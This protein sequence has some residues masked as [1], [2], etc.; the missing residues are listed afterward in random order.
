[1]FD[2][3]QSGVSRL[4]EVDIFRRVGG[5][6][7]PLLLLHGYPQT[8]V[9]WRKIA[10]DL[11]RDFT[12]VCPDLRGYGA[13]SKPV[14]DAANLLYSKRVM[15]ADM[16]ALMAEL[17]FE[18]FAV[19]GHDRGG[20]VA[21][22]LAFDHPA[23]VTKIATLD[24]V[25]T[26]AN[27]ERMRDMSIGLAT[28]HWYFL[29]QPGGLPEK[30]IGAD[31]D[32]Y[33]EEKLRRWSKDFAA[34]EPA[35]LAEYKRAFRDPACIAAT[36]ADYRAGATVDV[37]HDRADLGARKIAAPFLA[38]W[39]GKGRL[40]IEGASQLDVWRQWASDARGHPL[41][42]GHFLPEEAPAATLAGLR[43]FL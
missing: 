2:G 12:V 27:W 31:P 38:L 16:V 19:V 18:K 24:I 7:P 25:P 43:D 37:E 11:A 34:F 13:S 29:A 23:R 22:R 6:G 17:G 33:L 40:M 10:P 32:F 5:S 36:C 14:P 3:F 39:G 20:R 42:C 15:A 21:Y 30:M 8:H 9:L 1:M 4:G 41:D 28:Y 26:L 35:A